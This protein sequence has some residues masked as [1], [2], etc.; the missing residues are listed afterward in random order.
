MRR[1]ILIASLLIAS[2]I[3]YAQQPTKQDTL[4]WKVDIKGTHIRN[5]ILFMLDTSAIVINN[6]DIPAK[7]R[8]KTVGYLQAILNYMNSQFQTQNLP[9]EQPKKK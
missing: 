4:N 3:S 6:S 5:Q 2:A 8:T 7:D 9:K 1:I